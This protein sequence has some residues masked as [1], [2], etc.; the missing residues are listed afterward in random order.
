M[1]YSIS[2]AATLLALLAAAA[3]E[4]SEHLV[5]KLPGFKGQLP[6]RHFSGYIPVR[7]S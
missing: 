6:S 3:A 1:L 4:I 2:R 7:C 5:T